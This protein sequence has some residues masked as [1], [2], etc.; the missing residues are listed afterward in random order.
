[1]HFR[2]WPLHTLRVSISKQSHK[3][4]PNGYHDYAC[5]GYH[6]YYDHYCNCDYDYYG[7]CDYYGYSGQCDYGEGWGQ[8]RPA[9]VELTR[10]GTGQAEPS[11]AMLGQAG[12]N[13]KVSQINPPFRLGR[14]IM[15]PTTGQKKSESIQRD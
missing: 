3:Q 2:D 4:P 11:Q 1:M 13:H 6:G 12:L 9:R 5:Y 14:K 7:W 15:T 10:V 8:G